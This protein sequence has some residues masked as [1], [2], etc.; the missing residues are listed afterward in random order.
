MS[1]RGA[2]EVV[3]ALSETDGRAA[4]G[5]APRTGLPAATSAA[6]ATEGPG[7]TPTVDGDR[8]YVVGLGGGVSCLQV[9]DGKV[10][11]Q[12]QPHRRISAAACPSGATAN[13]RSW[14]ATR[15]SSPRVA[16]DATLVALDKLTGKTIWKSQVPRQSG[17]RPTRRPSPSTSKG[18]ASTCS[19]PR[20]RSSASRR[21][22]GSSSGDTTS[23][24]TANGI[25]CSTPIYHEGRC[26]RPPPTAPA[27]GS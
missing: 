1:H 12:A 13:R 2:E 14:T 22:T 24:P 17:G 20:R 18:S 9:A 16:T 19:S 7:S 23:P 15:S 6:Q 4:L 8:L 27:V 10:L 21:P 3:W 26:S 25:N 5:D 11:W